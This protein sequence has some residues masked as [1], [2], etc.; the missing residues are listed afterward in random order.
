MPNFY[1]KNKKIILTSLG[2]TLLVVCLIVANY[3]SLLLIKTDSES[4]SIKSNNFELYLLSL[5]KSQVEKEEMTLAEDYRLIGAG[6]FVWKNE[7]YYHVI[8]SAYSNKNDAILV[9][10][11]IKT[12]Q[13]LDSEIITISFESKEIIGNFSSEETKVL[14]KALN[15]FQEYYLSIYDI[16]ISL[17]TSV[18]NEISARLAVNNI[19]NNLATTIANFETIYK[20]NYV[21]NIKILHDAL[22]KASQT[23]QALCSGL[24]INTNQTYSSLLK[25]RYLEMLNIFY[26]IKFE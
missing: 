16:A 10:N 11:S 5:S 24:T 14:T 21:G 17:D 26:N 9:Q 2:A 13:N 19:H 4:T 8:S 18:Y 23:S 15:C 6:G 25:Y 1:K 22:K 3:L 7:N 12:N 20:D